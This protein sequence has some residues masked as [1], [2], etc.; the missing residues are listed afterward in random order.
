[1]TFFW[2]LN[3]IV[4]MW[5]EMNDAI[6]AQKLVILPTASTEQHGKHLPIDVD[7]FLCESVCMEVGRRAASQGLLDKLVVICHPA[8]LTS[9]SISQVGTTALSTSPMASLMRKV[10]AA[11]SAAVLATRSA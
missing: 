2:F 8:N 11:F 10:S 9:R 1:M 6:A 7:T 3:D 4:A 5:P